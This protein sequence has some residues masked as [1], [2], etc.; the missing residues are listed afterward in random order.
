[1]ARRSCRHAAYGLA[2]FALPGVNLE[3]LQPA[4]RPAVVDTL[5]AVAFAF[6]YQYVVAVVVTNLEGDV[7]KARLAIWMGLAIPLV[8]YVGWEGA[9]LGSIVPRVH[10]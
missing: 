1:V 8:M 5:P 10:H 9:T 4:S 3:N 7:R 2:E 6:V